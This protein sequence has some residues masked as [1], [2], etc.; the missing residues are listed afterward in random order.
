MYN[1]ENNNFITAYCRACYT[2][3][4][5]PMDEYKFLINHKLDPLCDDCIEKLV[6]EAAAE[7]DQETMR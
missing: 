2:K 3:H 6:D 7:Y 4:T 5:L 1:Y